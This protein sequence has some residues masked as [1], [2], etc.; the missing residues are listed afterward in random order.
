MHLFLIGFLFGF[1]LVHKCVDCHALA[2]M[3]IVS[4]YDMDDDIQQL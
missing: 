2:W 4:L 3:T 1:L